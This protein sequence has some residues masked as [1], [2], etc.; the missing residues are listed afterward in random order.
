MRGTVPRDAFAAVSGQRFVIGGPRGSMIIPVDYEWHLLVADETGLPAIARRVEELPEGIRTIVVAHV[1]PEDR[2]E[3][4]SRTSLQVQW[5][6]SDEALVDAVRALA[7]PPGEGYAW[8]A[9]EALGA[10]ADWD[11]AS[12][13]SSRPT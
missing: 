11:R 10:C 2:R 5:V 8:C 9:G 13:A 12:A 4:V 7:L 1:A 6:D 3:L